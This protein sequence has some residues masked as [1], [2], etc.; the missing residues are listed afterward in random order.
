MS[1]IFKFLKNPYYCASRPYDTAGAGMKIASPIVLLDNNENYAFA[2][3]KSSFFDVFPS[4][5]ESRR[6]SKNKKNKSRAFLKIMKI[7]AESLYIIQQ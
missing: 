2:G 6:T 7:K 3:I 5:M 4:N 1:L